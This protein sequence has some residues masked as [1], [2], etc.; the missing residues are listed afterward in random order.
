MVYQNVQKGAIAIGDWIGS[1]V[2]GV[3]IYHQRPHTYT[4]PYMNP[5]PPA[6]LPKYGV[7]PYN[8]KFNVEGVS[9]GI[10]LPGQRHP[11]LNYYNTYF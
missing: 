5:H 2:G 10:L 4:T 11:T 3:A 7:Y 1:I 6:L 9:G 8:T